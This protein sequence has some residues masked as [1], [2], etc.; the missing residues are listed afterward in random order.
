MCP[1]P[2]IV[3]ASELRQGTEVVG[4]ARASPGPD[5]GGRLQSQED[6]IRAE[7]EKLGLKL[8]IHRGGIEEGNIGCERPLLARAIR[9]ATSHQQVIVARDL[10]RIAKPADFDKTRSANRLPSQEELAQLFAGVD[11][12]PQFA[13]ILPP[14]LS[15]HEV[16]SRLIQS[17]MDRARQ[18]G[19][20]LGRRSV[21]LTDP[22]FVAQVLWLRQFGDGDELLTYPHEKSDGWIAHRL[23]VKRRRVQSVLDAIV[24]E[25]EYGPVRWR[26]VGDRLGIDPYGLWSDTR[27]E[28]TENLATNRD[29]PT[30]PLKGWGN[31][32]VCGASFRSRRKDRTTC[33]DKCRKASNRRVRALRGAGFQI[34]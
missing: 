13:T 15:W 28:C 23:N 9:W 4:Y 26:D 19:K 21:I 2:S 5:Y 22:D 1:V 25:D 10:F 20:P 18:Q 24:T 7:T 3:A 11:P 29:I 32:E 6:F 31:C 34:D 17:G 30:D 27:K 33:T 8:K 16:Q 14:D 12:L